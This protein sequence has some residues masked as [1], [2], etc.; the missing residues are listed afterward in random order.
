MFELL[1]PS[2]AGRVH[3]T[4]VIGKINGSRTPDLKEKRCGKQGQK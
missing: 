2:F 3:A 1:V 4:S